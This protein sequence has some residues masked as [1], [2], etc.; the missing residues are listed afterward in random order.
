[1]GEREERE[2]ATQP[3]KPEYIPYSVHHS[4]RI[5]FC[6]CINSEF[7]RHTNKPT[8]SVLYELHSVNQTISNSLSN[9]MFEAFT[10]V[11]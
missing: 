6:G 1:M 2:I 11:Q 8:Y 4:H 7:M 3:V 9:L 10:Q 5:Q